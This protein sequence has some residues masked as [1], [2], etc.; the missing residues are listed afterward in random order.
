M[1][2]N[3]I[4]D[5]AFIRSPKVICLGE[6]LIDRL[7]PIGEILDQQNGFQDCLGGAPAN[8]A[9]A[10]S[11]L[12]VK[13]SLVGRLGNDAIGERFR[14]FLI[15]RQVNIVALQEDKD[16]PTR[17][18]LVERDLKG[19]RSFGGFKGDKGY[20]FADQYIES[21]EVSDHWPLL[22]LDAKWLL[23]GTIPLASKSSSEAVF[24]I[25]ENAI[26]SGIKVVIDVNWRPTFW[27]SNASPH[28]GP[29]KIALSTIRPVLEIASLIKLAKEE[30]LW[31]FD[32]EDPRYIS[33]SLPQNPDIVIT[34]G[35]HPIKW[36]LGDFSG[37][38]EIFR[39]SIVVDT[40]GA[41]DAF[42]AGVIFQLLKYP[43]QLESKDQ[44]KKIIRFASACGALVCTSP[45]AIEFQP[46]FAQVETFIHSHNGGKI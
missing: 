37:E 9:C 6:A 31:F 16:R 5:S 33:Q 44:A 25:L 46:N 28:Q 19:E 34:D 15:E 22:S 43:K 39:P 20:G 2:S 30:A 40:T 7:G 21:K 17:I 26:K 35:A 10:L 45:G 12:G 27:R 24:F 14:D 13:A 4:I 1:I 38:M 42:T 29:D 3:T 8:V 41:G 36:L 32:S 18:V 11:Q 23:L